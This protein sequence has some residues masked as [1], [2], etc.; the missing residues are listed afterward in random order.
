M[1]GPLG[2]GVFGDGDG[3][4]SKRHGRSGHQLELRFDAG[5]LQLFKRGANGMGGC[6]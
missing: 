2:S 5:K 4:A 6:S 1:R 3:E